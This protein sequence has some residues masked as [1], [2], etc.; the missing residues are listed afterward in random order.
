MEEPSIPCR[1]PRCPRYL[2]FVPMAWCLVVMEWTA[3][4]MDL[5]SF[6]PQRHDTGK[7]PLQHPVP[8][9]ALYYPG[10]SRQL[11]AGIL[12]GGHV[13]GHHGSAWRVLAPAPETASRRQ[14]FRGVW[15][16]LK[17]PRNPAVSTSL[18]PTST[19]PRI[20]RFEIPP[21]PFNELNQRVAFFVI[22]FPI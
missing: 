14:G 16:A 3:Q 15:A 17:I 19:T 13:Y 6:P 9:H 18:Q 5:A 7:L 21:R 1:V 12:E 11:V 4:G 20:Q 22:L 8:S 10:R 2:V